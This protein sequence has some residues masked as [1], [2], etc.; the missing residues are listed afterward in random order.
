MYLTNEELTED[1][2]RRRR[3]REHIA[4]YYE[5]KARDAIAELEQAKEKLRRALDIGAVFAPDGV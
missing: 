5:A 2:D 1:L 3:Q 4:A